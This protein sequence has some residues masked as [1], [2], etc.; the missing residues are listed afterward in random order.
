MNIYIYIYVSC[1]N[2]MASD[3]SD[4]GMEIGHGSKD[5]ECPDGPGG[6]ES[7]KRRTPTLENR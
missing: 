3:S 2:S 4:L 1:M 5:R 6:I 7:R